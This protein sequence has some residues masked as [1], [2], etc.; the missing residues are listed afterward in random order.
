MSASEIVEVLHHAYEADIGLTIDAPAVQ[1]RAALADF[2][3]CHPDVKAA[4]W[5]LWRQALQGKG[6]APDDAEYWL[7]Q[8]F[9]GLYP[10][11]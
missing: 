4:V 11:G 2:L 7:N 5:T 3:A 9:T 10:Q 6:I 1:E 8:E